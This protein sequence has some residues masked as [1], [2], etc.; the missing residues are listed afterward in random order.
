MRSIVICL[1]SLTLAADWPR[2]RGPNGGGIAEATPAKWTATENRLWKVDLPGVGNSSPII[3]KGKLFVQSAAK[4]GSTR[5]LVCLDA[6][7]G[8]EIWTKTQSGQPGKTHTKNTLASSTP[9]SD[10]QRIYCCFWDGRDVSLVAYDFAGEQLWSEKIGPFV[11]QHGPAMSPIVHAGKVFVNFDSDENAEVRAF[12][13]ATG[14]KAWTQPR[15]HFRAC[16]STPIIRELPGGGSEIIVL[17]TAAL[18]A[19]DPATGKV[20]W[21][22]PFTWTGMPLRFIA[23]P[24][25]LGDMVIVLSGDGSSNARYCCG[26]K[27]G[28]EPKIVWQNKTSKL[29]PYVPCALAAGKHLFWITDNGVIECVNPLTGKAVWTERDAYSSS[30]SASPI[31]LG[32]AILFIDERGKALAVK[33]DPQSYEK[34]SASDVGEPVYATPAAADGRLY[35]RGTTSIICIGAK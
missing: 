19:Y 7:T 14:K 11:S 26:V 3:V 24:I 10:G 15:K 35:I 34:L 21:E 1:A 32:D 9:A 22:L 5:S 31:L 28:R 27:P 25:L 12:D 4:D 8:K 6:V 20:N 30:I 16:Y 2:F 29:A 13:A 18:T 33:A 23:S 17:S